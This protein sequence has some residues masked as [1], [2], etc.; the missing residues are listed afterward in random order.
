M[1]DALDGFRSSLS[2]LTQSS[3]TEELQ[4]N[5]SKV[6]DSASHLREVTSESRLDARGDLDNS[7]DDFTKDIEDAAE[8]DRPFTGTITVVANAIVNVQQH[9]GDVQAEAG[10]G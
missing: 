8:G 1:C 5:A 9:L 6:R 7:L 2:T 3:S 4:D 10:C